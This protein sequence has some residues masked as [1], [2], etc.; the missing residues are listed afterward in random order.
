M[1][2]TEKDPCLN[3]CDSL[4]YCVNTT[5]S[6]RCQCKAGF[7]MRRG[8]CVDLNECPA[9][10]HTC[11]RN[12]GI[13]TNT[14]GRFK[15][16]CK[17]PGFE[18]NG[19][20][21]KDINECKRNTHDCHRPLARCTNTIGSYKCTCK[22]GFEE[23]DCGRNCIGSRGKRYILLFMKTIDDPKGTRSWLGQIYIASVKKQT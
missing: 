8:R 23:R 1:T 10:T 4:S 11:H 13:C 21:C 20:V 12:Y 18:G 3:A 19:F 22:P 2:V 7:I 6:P 14:Y 15:C 5:G 16:S 17:K 9:Y